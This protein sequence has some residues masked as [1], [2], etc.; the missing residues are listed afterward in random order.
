MMFARR[1]FLVAGMA[2]V[3]FVMPMY[4]LEA[5]IGQPR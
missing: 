4:F 3:L 2:G 1:V 5:R